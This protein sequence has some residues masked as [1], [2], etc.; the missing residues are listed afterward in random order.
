MSLKVP[1]GGN[2]HSYAR[3]F[4]D[5]EHGLHYFA[6]EARAVRSTAAAGVRAGVRVR[7]Q[8]MVNQVTVSSVNLHAVETG[9][10]G[11]G[12]SATIVLDRAPNLHQAKCSELRNIDKTCLN[13]RLRPSPN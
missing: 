2:A 10:L 6:K 12:S 8:E 9:G 13:D 1:R 11:I 7:P 4:P 3:R 5:R